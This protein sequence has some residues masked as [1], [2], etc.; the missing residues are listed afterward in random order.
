MTRPTADA[1]LLLTRLEQAGHTP[2]LAPLMEIINESVPE[3]ATDFAG[4][5]GFAFTSANGVRALAQIYQARQIPAFVVGA[6][7]EAQALAEG[8]RLA[9]VA[10]GSVEHLAG[11]IHEKA[12]RPASIVHVGGYDQAGDL[13]ADLVARGMFARR[14]VLYR[15][16]AVSGFAPS[17]A[18]ALRNVEIEV[19]TFFSPRTAKLFL[20][21]LKQENMVSVLVKLVVVCLSPAVAAVFEGYD[22]AEI[23]VAKLPKISAMIDIIEM[24]RT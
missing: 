9:G 5:T 15:A 16:R 17:V 10:G 8:F 23:R 7:T 1:D 14:L 13:V 22:C 3:S 12:R 18:A 2:I 11:V 21:R 19:A 4:V 6:A 20:K 24:D